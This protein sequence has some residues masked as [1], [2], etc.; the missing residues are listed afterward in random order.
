METSEWKVHVLLTGNWRT[1][2]SVLLSNGRRHTVVDT[3]MPHEAHLLVKA[4]EQ[5][6][7]R[8]S[9]VHSLINTHFHIDHVLNNVL[10]PNSLI[11]G[12][13]ESYE[14]CR[15]LYS[16]LRDEQC[17]EKLVLNYYP[18][19][20]SYDHALEH[21]HQLRKFTLRWWDVNRLGTQSQHRWI[22]QHSLPDGLEP[23]FT[24][25]HVPGHVSVIIPDGS[26]PTI[27]A[28]DA[29]LSRASD[30]RIL[31]MIPYNREQSRRDREQVLARG[32]RI[33]PGHDAEFTNEE[34]S[35]REGECS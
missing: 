35:F 21:M 34:G 1:A 26:Q 12:S 18:E 16:D 4:L 29:F 15:S 14:W 13:Q 5:Y 25:G 10:F 27:I 30:D 17:W 6:G 31:T 20:S 3:G 19:T 8:A 23:L 28:G 2:T 33:F 24:S 7:L 22:E 11:Y 32:A 9:D